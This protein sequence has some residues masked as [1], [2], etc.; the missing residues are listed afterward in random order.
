M[1]SIFGNLLGH[2]RNVTEFE[3]LFSEGYLAIMEK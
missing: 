2:D 3:K 1:G